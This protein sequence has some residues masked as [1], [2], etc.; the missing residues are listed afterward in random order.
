MNMRKCHY[1]GGTISFNEEKDCYICDYC[2]N[3]VMPSTLIDEE[4][5]QIKDRANKLYLA[6]DFDGAATLYQSIVSKYVDEAEAY[7]FLALCAYGVQY[8][9]DPKTGKKSQHA[10]ELYI[11]QY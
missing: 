10:T 3:P 8:V 5:E 11:L 2:Q 1:C 6:C 7:W 9:D 4:I